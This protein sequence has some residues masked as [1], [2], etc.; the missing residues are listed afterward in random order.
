MRAPRDIR[1]DTQEILRL[2]SEDDDGEEEKAE[3]EP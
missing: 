3:E 1:T 2:L